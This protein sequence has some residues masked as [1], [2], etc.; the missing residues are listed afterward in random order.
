M[1]AADNIGIGAI[2]PGEILR[3]DFLIGE[4]IP[5]KEVTSGTGLP[6]ERLRALQDGRSAVDA[7]VDMRLGRYFGMSEGFFLRLQNSYD[8]SLA[9][10]A[11][12]A[13]YDRLAPR[14]A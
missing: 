11:H 7:D 14:A 3:D 5:F 10:R 12:G 13:E 4:E 2:H 1:T 8:L 6:S 9:K